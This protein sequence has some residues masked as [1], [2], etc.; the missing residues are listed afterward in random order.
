MPMHD[1]AWYKNFASSVA[2][3]T[4]LMALVLSLVYCGA[5]IG[6]VTN[7]AG[8]LR[9]TGLTLLILNVAPLGRNRWFTH[10]TAL[11]LYTLAGVA[12]ASWFLQQRIRSFCMESDHVG[13]QLQTE[14]LGASGPLYRCSRY[15]LIR[16]GQNLG[17]RLQQSSRGRETPA[18]P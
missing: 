17:T 11:M 1:G 13:F 10:G 9:V 2:I 18:Q 15:R 8:V 16:L 14:T 5:R 6:F 7:Y 12:T 3:F 4:S